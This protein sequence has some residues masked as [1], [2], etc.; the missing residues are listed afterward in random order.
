MRVIK[1][2][3]IILSIVGVGIILLHI[4]LRNF[5]RA[6][7]IIYGVSF[8]TEYSYYLGLDPKKVLETILDDWKFRYLRLTAQWNQIEPQ[9]GQYN[10]Q[11]LDWS[12]DM[13]ATKGAKVLL[14]VGY[15]TPRWPECHLPAWADMDVEK[16]RADR[17][18]YIRQVIERYKSHPALEIWQVENEPFLAFGNCQK[19]SP[20]DLQEEIELV[21]SIDSS[22]LII[23]T[24]SGELS[25]WHRT[26]K[27]T[28]LFGTTM[29]R[30]V[31]NKFIGYF[32]Y[33]WLM[34]A[35]VYRAKLWFNNRD[36]NTAYIT[37]LQ[38]EPWIPNKALTDTPLPEQ[39]K[40]MNLSRLK[41]N[42]DFA[43]KTGMPRAYLWGAE[44][45][46]WLETKGE[47]DIPN[48]IKSLNN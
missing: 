36:I 39:F 43:S 7:E 21:K 41:K 40:S 30:V 42:L 23:T 12:M 32:S 13:A 9:Q 26:A 25:L 44:W 34:P 17:Q 33:D 35:F 24:D 47:K 14:A 27:V 1:L 29:Y 6:G 46:Y 16:N 45:W 37:E 5:T 10:W 38:A 15:K 4:K 11:D 28:D 31:W 20:Q 18:E 3:V 2:L 48:I 19:F 22:H 8:N